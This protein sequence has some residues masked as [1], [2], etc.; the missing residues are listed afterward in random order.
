MLTAALSEVK[1]IVGKCG[2]NIIKQLLTLAT[3]P[4]SNQSQMCDDFQKEV[5]FNLAFLSQYYRSFS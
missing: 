3:S 4:P 2:V 5:V 1:G